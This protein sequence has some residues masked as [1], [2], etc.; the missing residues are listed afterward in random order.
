M[1]Y[2]QFL[3]RLDFFIWNM[4]DARASLLYHKKYFQMLLAVNEVEI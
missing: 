4:N 3:E 1:S 2:I